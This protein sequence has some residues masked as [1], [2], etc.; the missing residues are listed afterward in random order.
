MKFSD[1][2]WITYIDLGKENNEK[3]PKFGIGDHVR[4]S[5]YKN[6]FAKGYVPNWSEEAVLI[7]KV[8]NLV[9]Y[10]Y[11]VRDPKN[12]LLQGLRTKLQKEIKQN[13]EKKVIMRKG[14]KLYVKFVE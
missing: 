2:K 12:E 14:G 4:I 11:A 8:K 7:T 10:T 3:D 5:K 6:I 1:V 9:L 13:F